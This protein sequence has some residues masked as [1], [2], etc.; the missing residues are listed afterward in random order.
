MLLNK[1]LDREVINKLDYKSVI[2]FFNLNKYFR[3]IVCDNQFFYRRLE[4]DYPGI[5]DGNY[6][7]SFFY[8]YKLKKFGYTYSSKNLSPKYQY[9]Q[10]KKLIRRIF[11]MRKSMYRPIDEICQTSEVFL[12]IV[13]RCNLNLIK[14]ALTLYNFSPECQKYGINYSHIN[15]IDIIKFF[16]EKNFANNSII[17]RGLQRAIKLQDL[18]MINYFT[19]NE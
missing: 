19:K 10:V 13:N 6:K 3:N 15:D 8:I 12:Y 2:T 7:Q 5:K 1:D 4:K 16:V 11:R 17:N 18:E 14:F 9:R